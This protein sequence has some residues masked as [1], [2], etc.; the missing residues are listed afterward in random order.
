M[1]PHPCLDV[2]KFYF[3]GLRQAWWV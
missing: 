3:A 1:L 2:C